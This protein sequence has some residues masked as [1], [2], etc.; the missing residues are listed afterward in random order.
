[1]IEVLETGLFQPRDDKC[2]VDI[3]GKEPNQPV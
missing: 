1:M 3:L 2:K